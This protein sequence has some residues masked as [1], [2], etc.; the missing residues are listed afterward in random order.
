MTALLALTLLGVIGYGLTRALA[1]PAARGVSI[2]AR[3]DE[4]RRI[5]A[6]ES[7]GRQPCEQPLERP[8]GGPA[9]R[10]RPRSYVAHC[11]GG[12]ALRL[13]HAPRS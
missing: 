13:G 10:D 9:R 3:L 1:M 6:E 12:P 4:A 11:D 8:G 2:A 7:V 5:A